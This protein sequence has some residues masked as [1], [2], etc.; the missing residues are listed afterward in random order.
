MSADY[1]PALEAN[2]VGLL[3]KS[4][5]VAIDRFFGGCN[6][7]V[8]NTAHVWAVDGPPRLDHLSEWWPAERLLLFMRPIGSG[9][10]D[11]RLPKGVVPVRQAG[12]HHTN[13]FL[14]QRTRDFLREQ[15]GADPKRG[16]RK[17]ADV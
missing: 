6:D 9:Q 1:D 10:V 4:A 12:V 17:R 16:Q 5:D 8:V 2:V 15:L 7:L 13:M 3:K 11:L 14:L